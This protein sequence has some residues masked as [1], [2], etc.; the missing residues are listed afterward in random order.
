MPVFNIPQ[1]A[2]FTTQETILVASEA[3]LSGGKYLVDLVPDIST[4]HIMA[5]S[6]A[7]LGEWQILLLEWLLVCDTVQEGRH[8]EHR[9]LS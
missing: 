5:K 4:F 3:V 1:P 9:K 2:L 8:H 7:T 6:R